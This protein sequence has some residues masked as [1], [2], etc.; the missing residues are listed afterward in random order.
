MTDTFDER[1]VMLEALL[2]ASE[3]PQTPN[4]ISQFLGRS[5]RKEL[6][7]LIQA[8]NDNYADAGR[9]FRIREIAEGYQMYLMPTY[10]RAVE[11]FLSKQ[12]ERRL[13]QAALE[14]LAV[15]AYKQPVTRADVEHVRGVNS[16]GVISSL[17]ERKLTA[18]VGR[19]H[20]VG[21]PLLYGTTKQFL[22][23]FGLKSLEE[24]PRLDE[25]A[26]P[27]ET[28][29][30]KSQVELNLDNGGDDDQR[31]A[32]LYPIDNE[33]DEKTGIMGQEIAL[34]TDVIE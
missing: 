18:I 12:K 13:S 11:K 10:T 22:E 33:E 6:P 30:V 5:V 9:S 2:F 7:D 15:V 1:L 4:R 34:E 3:S 8:L 23:Y 31:E 26:L 20:K 25:L 24:L 17:L 21:R 32:A 28:S 19:S 14:T 27:E 29:M 16:D